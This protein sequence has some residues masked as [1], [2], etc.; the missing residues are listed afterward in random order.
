MATAAISN[1]GQDSRFDGRPHLGQS[2]LDA[3]L[4]LCPHRCL[5]PLIAPAQADS[6]GF[7]SVPTLSVHVLFH[8]YHNH[9]GHRTHRVQVAPGLDSEIIGSG[10][11]ALNAHA[12]H[13]AGRLGAGG[14]AT[15]S[16]A[17]NARCLALKAV[18]RASHSLRSTGN[19]SVR[20]G[21]SL[22]SSTI[23]AVEYFTW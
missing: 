14:L 3:G 20:S 5:A 9:I 4:P 7:A 11:Q 2:Q 19:G 23:F 18:A 6:L 13:G 10:R 16:A 21:Q 17:Q 1:E 8:R 22:T 15:L 12:F